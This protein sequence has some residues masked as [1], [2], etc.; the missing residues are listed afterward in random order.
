[1]I[2]IKLIL[3]ILAIIFSFMWKIEISIGLALIYFLSLYFIDKRILFRMKSKSFFLFLIFLLLIY[4]TTGDKQGL[5]LPMGINYDLELMLIS[6]RMCLRAVLIFSL[7]AQLLLSTNSYKI[8]KFWKKLGIFH[9][10]ALVY[11]SEAIMPSIKSNLVDLWKK[12]KSKELP[13]SSPTDVIATFLAKLLI[14]KQESLEIII[15]E[16]SNE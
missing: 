6:V 5:L 15:K 9:Y 2:L 16:N 13:I 3:P 10:E 14:Q 7:F 1:M 4:P 11:E 12:I 8:E